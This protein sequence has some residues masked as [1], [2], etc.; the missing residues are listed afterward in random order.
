GHH[1]S[2]R[3]PGDRALHHGRRLRRRDAL[4]DDPGAVLQVER[5]QAHLPHGA[6]ASPLRAR[7]L[8][9]K[10]GG[11]A[12][13]DHHHDAG[14][15]RPLDAQAAMMRESALRLLP[16]PEPFALA[17]RRVLVLGLGDTGL[18]LARYAE[19]NEARVRIAD[20]RVKPPRLA[21]FAGHVHLGPFDH[22]LPAAVDLVC[23][24]PGLS[25]AQPLVVAALAR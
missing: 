8:E 20:T 14:A 19:R 25:L 4:G 13:L 23:V 2:D 17:G 12:L 6:A 21:D 18:S 3:V 11:G 10:P 7:R 5:R 24:S 15:L 16:R 9:G 22:A 1:R